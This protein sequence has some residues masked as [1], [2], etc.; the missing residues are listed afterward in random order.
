MN[1]LLPDPFF[2]AARNIWRVCRNVRMI[3]TPK[4]LVAIDDVMQL[5]ARVTAAEIEL[6]VLRNG[7]EYFGREASGFNGQRIRKATFN[8][9]CAAIPFDVF[10]E[11]GTNLGM[12]TGFL[13]L[14]TGKKVFSCEI[15]SA[16]CEA[17]RR[18]L[19]IFPNVVVENSD[20]VT[21]LRG[22]KEEIAG[23]TVFFY[24][25]AH[26]YKY[27]PL[28]DELDVIGESV[29]DFVILIDDFAVPGDSGYG[30]DAY[31]ARRRLSY[32]YISDAV[33]RYDLGCFFPAEAS[34]L[35]T[36]GR[37]GYALLSSAG[38]M[39]RALETVSALR[40]HQR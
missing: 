27:L 10:V 36:G 31:S 11:T 39:T 23:R 4:S 21:F 33:R 12:T 1:F 3:L 25:D 38:R 35:E 18:N 24:L 16:S 19:S 8:E 13:A 40:K 5:A 9:I 37:R 29:A 32:E 26:W 7:R 6:G 28:L 30:Y 20:S 17:A 22:L 34:R 14:N 2:N 15:L